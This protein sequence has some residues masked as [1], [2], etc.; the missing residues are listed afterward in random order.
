MIKGRAQTNI[1]SQQ[2]AYGL[3]KCRLDKWLWASRLFKTRQDAADACHGR[4]V[5]LDGRVVDKAHA[6]VR[7]GS[8]I[9]FAAFGT[10]RVAKVLRL[11]DRRVSPPEVPS[12]YQ[13]LSPG[14]LAQDLP[15]LADGQ[16]TSEC[17]A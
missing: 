7:H 13:D 3:Q 9:S 15:F 6:P 8:V 10:V 16:A 14:R 17:R 2:E 12:V 5:R 4:K 1:N 11:V